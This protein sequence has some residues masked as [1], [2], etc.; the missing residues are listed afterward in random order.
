MRKMFDLDQEIKGAK[1]IGIA[2]HIRPDGDCVGSCLGLG[3]YLRENYP[4]LEAVDI[5]LES[6]P[7]KFRVLE[8]TETICTSYPEKTYDVFFSLDCGDIG[9]LGNAAEYLKTAGKVICVDHHI[10][11]HGFGDVQFIEPAASSTS[12]LIYL[13]LDDA[14]LSVSAAK[15]LYMGIAHDTGVFQ[16]SCTS[17][18]TMEIAGKLMEKGFD[19]N[20]LLDQT[21]FQKTYLQNQILGRAL[22][23]SMLLMDG[24]CIISA[25]RK[26]DLDFYGV[27]SEDLDGIVSQLRNTTGVEVAIFLYETAI[28]EFKVS[29]RSNGRVVLE[30]TETI[31]TSYPE[32]TYDVFFSLDCGDIGRLGNAAE[33]LKTAGKVICVD[34]HI[35]NHGFGDV[36]FIEPA[37]SSTSELIY[38][39]LDDAELSV[40]AAKALY[41]GIAHDTGVFQ[42]S[43]TSRRTMEIAGKL[44][45]KGFDF[46]ELLDQTFFQK[47]YLQNQILGRALLESMLLMDGKCIISALRKKDLDFY[48]V[49]SEDLDGIV[50]Q[51]RNTTG[52]EVAIF[53]YETAIQEFKV[54]LRS[55][56]RVDVSR[57]ASYFGGGGHVRAAG[58]TMQGSVYDVLNNLTLHI[59][60]QLKGADL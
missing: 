51:L 50:S 30:G 18:R 58:C 60:K 44:M 45:E 9:R 49:T 19:F 5:H 56:G 36:Q 43:C 41:M 23:E 33:Y 4:E 22:L 11:N 6:V 20:E 34:H 15:A 17:R 28:Q 57:V 55:N 40:S 10:S 53:L 52:V 35:S 38:L 31:C 39:L 12:E 14:E 54:S 24:K 2:G 21:F 29:L 32:K 7:E 8:G 37:A 3:L 47:T 13:L 16:Y 48:G 46:N 1:R 26:K 59:E 25:L 42:Y 27:T